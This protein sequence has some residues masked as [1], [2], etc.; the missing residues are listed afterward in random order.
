MY[1]YLSAFMRI[2]FI[3]SRT[4]LN[5]TIQQDSKKGLNDL[6]RSNFTTDTE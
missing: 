1:L 2:N 4:H 6:G 5:D 3:I